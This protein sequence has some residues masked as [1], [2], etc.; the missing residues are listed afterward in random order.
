MADRITVTIGG[1]EIDLPP[2]MT[3][4]VLERAWPAIQAFANAPDGVAQTSAGLAV[5]AASLLPTRPELTVAELKKR[6][7][8]DRASGRGE[9][10][11]LAE[12]VDALIKASGLFPPPPPE[13]PGAPAA[14]TA[15]MA[16]TSNTSSQ[17]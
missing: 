13:Q 14:E 5:V 8:V 7:R 3:F 1:E 11:I 6:L 17:S 4:D 9:R 12:G 15:E 2:I 10:D 16:Q